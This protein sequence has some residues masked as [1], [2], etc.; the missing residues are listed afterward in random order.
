MAEEIKQTK[1][2]SGDVIK[3]YED[4][5]LRLALTYAIAFS[6]GFISASYLFMSGFFA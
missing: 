3:K 5:N 6:I 1:N 2:V 4:F